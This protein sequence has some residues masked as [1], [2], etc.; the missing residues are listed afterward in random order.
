MVILNWLWTSVLN[1][2]DLT[3]TGVTHSTPHP[4]RHSTPHPI[5]FFDF[6]IFLSKQNTAYNLNIY[7]RAKLGLHKI[8]EELHFFN[9]IKTKFELRGLR[10]MVKPWDK[11]HFIVYLGHEKILCC[12]L[13]LF[14]IFC[15]LIIFKKLGISLIMIDS[16]R[17]IS[18]QRFLQLFHCSNL[19][20]KKDW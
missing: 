4:I 9:F 18:H 20:W 16:A 12:A 7:M 10:R 5:R 17:A 14:S 6:L 13:A 19:R 3:R 11:N 1:F 8:Q 15:K 2:V